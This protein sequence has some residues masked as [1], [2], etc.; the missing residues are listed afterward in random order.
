MS[1]IQKSNGQAH[2]EK[3]YKPSKIKCT[4]P[5]KED[6]QA[7]KDKKNE[8]IEKKPTEAKKNKP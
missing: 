1:S 3:I 8:P 2:K 4:S 7:F 5:Q 6:G